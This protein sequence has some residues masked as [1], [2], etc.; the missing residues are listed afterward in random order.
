LNRLEAMALLKEL[1]ASDL[2]NPDY[3]SLHKEK[4]ESYQIQIKCGYNEARIKQYAKNND[5][6]ITEDKERK[7]L[8]IYKP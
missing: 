7:Y 3:V 2:V 8:F 6:I 5:L 1:V 4:S